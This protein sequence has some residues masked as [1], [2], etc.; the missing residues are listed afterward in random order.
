VSECL[1]KLLDTALP[2]FAE[3]TIFLKVIHLTF[4]LFFLSILGQFK[5][6]NP[7][8][9]SWI[10]KPNVLWKL[11]EQLAL[12][13]WNECDYSPA[14]EGGEEYPC[15]LS[16]LGKGNTETYYYSYAL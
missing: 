6:Q 12:A 8:N 13:R 5:T 3:N 2:S 16:A 15:K 7:K 10:S 11:L 4:I 14:V 9:S 1:L